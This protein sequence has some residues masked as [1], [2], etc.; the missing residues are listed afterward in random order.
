MVDFAGWDMPIQYSTINDEHHAVRKNAGLF[1]IAHMGRLRFR[2][3]QAEAFLDSLLTNDVT[4]MNVGQIRYS[5]VCNESGGIL[6]DVLVYRFADSWMLVVNASNREK[7]LGWIDQQR[8]DADFDMTDETLSTFMA[9]LQGPQSTRLMTFQL[10]EQAETLSYYHALEVEL[11]GIGPSIVSRTGYTGE[12]GFEVIVPQESGQSWWTQCME[13]GASEGLQPCGLGCRD[14]LRLEAAMPLYGH[15][16]DETV[17]PFTAGLDFGVRLKAGDF[18]GKQALIEASKR[19]ERRRRIGLV[20]KERRIA[21]TGA[22]ILHAGDVVGQ[23][24]SGTFSPTLEVSIAMGYVPSKLSVP[25]TMLDIDIRGKHV[26]AEVVP[27]PFYKA[28]R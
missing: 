26:A 16:M 12:D 27:L 18:I 15:E 17:D 4:R 21:R 24:S 5:L 25:G 19:K 8:G 13:T 11:P 3:P 1:D 14:T 23:V 7:I 22:D 20:L 6:D 10:S 9:A 2:G 28:T